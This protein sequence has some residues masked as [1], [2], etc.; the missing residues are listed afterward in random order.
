[1]SCYSISQRSQKY[2]ANSRDCATLIDR[3]SNELQDLE[4]NAEKYTKRNPDLQQYSEKLLGSVVHTNAMRAAAKDTRSI[5][6]QVCADLK[7]LAAESPVKRLPSATT[8]AN[9]LVT[10]QKELDGAQQLYQV[11]CPSIEGS[12]WNRCRPWSSP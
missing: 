5:F 2:Y 10:I 3:V 12:Y 4:D 7:A 8:I 11:R 9:R 1:M 6:N